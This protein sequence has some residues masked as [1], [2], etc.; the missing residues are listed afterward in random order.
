LRLSE[1]EFDALKSLYSARGARSISE[2]ARAAMQSVI[3]SQGD[4]AALELR[5]QEIDRRLSLLDSEVASLSQ[6]IRPVHVERG[7]IS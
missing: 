1:Q 3:S 6:I 4:Y 5:I 7:P 2:F